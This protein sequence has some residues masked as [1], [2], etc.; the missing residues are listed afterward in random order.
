M[1]LCVMYLSCDKR[2]CRLL[3]IGKVL[4]RVHCRVVTHKLCYVLFVNMYKLY[5]LYLG[6][7]HIQSGGGYT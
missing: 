1:Y 4:D 5:G 7:V 3:T 2:M 6:K